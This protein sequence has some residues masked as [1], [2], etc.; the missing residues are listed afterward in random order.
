MASE[1]ILEMKKQ[2]VQEMAAKLTEA[3]SIVLADYR[4]LTVEEDTELRSK[5]RAEGIEYKVVK[6]NIIKHA[7]QGTDLE[8]LRDFLVGPTSIAISNDEVAPAKV[9][10][11]FAKDLNAFELKAG[12]VDGK[13]IDLAGIE[14]LAKLPSKEQLIAKMLGSMNSPITGLVTVLSANIKGL[15]VALNAIIEKNQTES[16]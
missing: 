2:Q 11:K 10:F 7:I 14:Q 6:N 5:M 4:G 3:G 16:A 1:K 15:A 9:M 13:V 8:S 12:V